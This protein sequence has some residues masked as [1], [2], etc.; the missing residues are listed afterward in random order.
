MPEDS[1]IAV[2]W[3]DVASLTRQHYR[4]ELCQSIKAALGVIALLSIKG[5]DHCLVLVFEGGSGRGKSIIVRAI[6]S[7]RPATE[8]FLSRVDDFTPAS[9]VS[10][11]SNKTKKELESNDL[12]PQLKDKVMLTKELAPLFRDDEKELRQ[13]FARLTSVLD[14][15]GYKTHSGVHGRRGY[16]GRYVFNWVGA[17]TPIPDRTHKIMAQLGNRILFHEVAGE[18]P[19]EDDLLEFAKSYGANSAVQECNK[20]VNDFIEGHF[21]RN[22]RESV[23]PESIKISEALLLEI[24]RYAKLIASGRTEVNIDQ[25]GDVEVGA[26]EGPQ[27]VILLLQ[28]LAR[29][30][31][32]VE[33]RSEVTKDDL[34]VIRHI[35]LSSI[36]VRRRELLRALLAKGRTMSAAQVESALGLSRPTALARMKELAA[37]GI[38]KFTPGN[39][40]TSTPAVITLEAEWQWVA[41]E[42]SALPD[43]SGP[44]ESRENSLAVI[45]A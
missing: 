24:I 13:N 39:P 21:Q 40:S 4:E 29:G 9:F 32:L 7:D 42:P 1:V 19:S 25:S 43:S 26:P 23:D 45:G 44:P 20:I 18:E 2:L 33:R 41:D 15:D 5:R 12:L 3:S 34:D 22:P 8:E 16:T 10:H 14:G 27:R 37:T 11:A 28:T 6:M 35:A 31:A 17:T 38:C 30:L 36:P